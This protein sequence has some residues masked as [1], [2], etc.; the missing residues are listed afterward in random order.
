MVHVEYT[1]D[2][3]LQ[4]PS[5]RAMKETLVKF[6]KVCKKVGLD[7]STNKAKVISHCDIKNE[8]IGLL[9]NDNN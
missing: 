6:G 5:L 2:I 1:D 8:A 3:L 4:A 9:L 7:I